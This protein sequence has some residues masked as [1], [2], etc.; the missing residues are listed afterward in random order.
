MNLS[1]SSDEPPVQ[2]VMLTP[3]APSAK[4]SQQKIPQKLTEDSILYAE[5]D[6]LHES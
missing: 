2:P 5:R 6:E 4:E 1:K 3:P